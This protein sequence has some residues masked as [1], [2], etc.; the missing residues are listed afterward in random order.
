MLELFRNFNLIDGI[1]DEPLANRCLVIDNQN[2]NI[3]EIG[4]IQE[5]KWSEKINPEQTYDL[6]GKWIIPGLIDCHVH[7]MRDGSPDPDSILK[8]DP[9]ELVALK[10]LHSAQRH[11]AIGITTVRDNGSIGLSVLSAKK[12]IQMGLFQGPRILTSGSPLIMTGGHFHVGGIEVD[13]IDEVTKAARNAFKKGVDFVKVFAT[14]GIYSQG[15]NPGS[16]QFSVD[17]LKAAVEVAR[18][19]N[20]KVVSH[21]QGREGIMNSLIA[22]VDSIEHAIYADEECLEKFVDQGT[23]LVPTMKTMVVIAEGEKIGVPS[24]A[25]EKAKEIIKIHFAMLQKAIQYGVKVVTGTDSCSPGNPP[26]NYFDELKI[27][28]DAGMSEMQVIQASTSIAA[29]ALGLG[30]SVGRLTKGAKADFLIL[31]DNPL[32]DLNHLRAV[33]RIFQS[34][35]EISLPVIKYPIQK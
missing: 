15:E 18:K 31:N 4:K 27:M 30:Q 13:G 32:E 21:A 23:Y 22:G 20:R 8:N 19:R 3:I 24:F 10:A 25:V 9:V 12:A 5:G 34:G 1:H 33:K 6:D 26:E 28:Q 17:E 16:S 35:K 2:G 11:L 29:D 7:L 14:G